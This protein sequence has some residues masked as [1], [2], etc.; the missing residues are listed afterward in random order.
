MDGKQLRVLFQQFNGQ[1]FS[2]RLPAYAI[3]VVPKM[4]SI[5]ESGRWN[6]IRRLI[7]IQRGLSN[8]EATGT[9]LHEMAGYSFSLSLLLFSSRKSR[10]SCALSKSF[11][12][13]S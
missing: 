4:T 6:K 12:H 13:C 1:F 7:E 10:K 5:G 11:D 3:R 9:L 2:G 8:D